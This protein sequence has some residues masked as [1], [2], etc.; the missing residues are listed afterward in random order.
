M[1]SLKPLADRVLVK[2]NEVKVDGEKYLLMR[3]DDIYAVV[4]A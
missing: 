3:A 1:S 2:P 4:E